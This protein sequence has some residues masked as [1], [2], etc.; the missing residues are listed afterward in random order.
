MEET[1]AVKGLTIPGT[2]QVSGVDCPD[3]A[4]KIE[5]A[6]CQLPGIGKASFAFGAGQLTVEYDPQVT[7]LSQV[8]AGIQALGYAAQEKSA[9]T[10]VRIF[11]LDCPDCAA[12]LEK[13]IQ[14]LPGVKRA[15]LNF[16]ASKLEVVHQ[17]PITEILTVIAEHGYQGKTEEKREQKEGR[18]LFWKTNRYALPAA[19]S[20]V[21]ILLAVFC[22]FWGGFTEF[23]PAIYTAAVVVGCYWPARN[24]LLMLVRGRQL[25][26]NFLMLVAA[27]GA[28]MIGQFEEAAAVVFLF[29]LGNALQVYTLG[30]TR[31]SIQTL[32]ELSPNK[33]LVRRDGKE[34]VLDV[35]EI[36]RGEIVIVRP[37]ERLPMDGLVVDGFSA[38]N[39]APLTGESMPV[40]KQPGDEVFAGTINGQGS[41]EISVTRLARDN[42]IARIIQMVEDAQAQRAPSQQFVDRFARYYTPIV[43]IG[44]LLVAVIP[45]LLFNQ[46]FSKWLYQALAMLLVACPCALVISTPVSIVSAIGNAARHGVLIKGGAYLEEMGNISVMAF[47]KTGTLTYGKPRVTDVIPIGK[48][49]RKRLLSLAA[50]IESR[51]EHLLGEAILSAAREQDV[52]V[53]AVTCF[54]AVT[55]MGAKGEISGRL[56]LIGSKRFFAEMGI[57]LGDAAR[58]M[59]SLQKDG[60]TA[61]AL[62][63]EEE[64]L[65]VI[66]VA[67]VLRNNSRST[68]RRLK[69]EGISRVVMLTGDSR[70]TARVV[71]EKVGVDD[72]R[73]ELMPE[74]KVRVVQDLLKKYQKVAMVGDGVND[75]PAM[76]V[77]T[78]GIAMGVAGTDTALETADIA[79][80]ADDLSKLPYAIKLSRKTVGIIKQNIFLALAI[81]LA[82]LSLVIPG[83]LTLWLAVVADMGSS[84]L[85]TLNGMRLIRVKEN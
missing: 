14:S 76:A 34:V 36:Q 56:Y 9:A 38:V 59:E 43:I 27:I 68:L 29:S 37:G 12:K 32:M 49:S 44:A 28:V 84:L 74:D 40:T 73:A 65:G 85:V 55:G 45:A 70:T 11:G 69:K 77:S 50:G 71:A 61:V 48:I 22:G 30:K 31:H 46:P 35:E 2:L 4:A 53:P 78:V 39:Q 17:N 52:P 63:T 57:A 41:L 1:A 19:V 24:G 5:R 33:A 16:G 51:S 82:I 67:D 21:L 18:E 47:D 64:I 23:T 72:Y 10:T 8:I 25:D 83:L 7:D 54:Q 58:V 81:K 20:G 3:C 79:L 75:A 6:V 60:K 66:A 62:G 13:R 26:I 15:V 80:M 42:T